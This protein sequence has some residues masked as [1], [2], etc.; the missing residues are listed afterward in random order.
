MSVRLAVLC[1]LAVPTAA[2]P[3][4]AEDRMHHLSMPA[5]AGQAA[6]AAIAEVVAW[7]EADPATDWS[8]VDIG[9]L[10]AHL[11]DMDAVVL[12]SRVSELPIDG[13]LEMT[14]TGDGPVA[15]AIG[16][17]VTAHAAELDAL[18]GLTAQAAETEGGAVLRVTGDSAALQVRIRA[19]GFYGLL[20]TG[21]HHQAHHLAI[22]S[23]HGPHDH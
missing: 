22:A 5:E 19:L 18:P 8:R 3:A 23:G 9:A 10:Q 1:A 11:V 6:F 2:S 14:I 15:G 4:L 17:M 7:L 12:R 20:A 13:G 21:A 16:R